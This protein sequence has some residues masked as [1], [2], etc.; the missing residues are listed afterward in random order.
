LF[1]TKFSDKSKPGEIQGRKTTGPRLNCMVK[2]DS[3]VAE[4]IHQTHSW[5]LE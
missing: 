3:R 5:G 1:E 2:T 4:E